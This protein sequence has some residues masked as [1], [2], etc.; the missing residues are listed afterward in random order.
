V[1]SWGATLVIKL[2]ERERERERESVSGWTLE[3]DL[4]R[5]Q[6]MHGRA[7]A[8]ALHMRQAV[9]GHSRHTPVSDASMAQLQVIT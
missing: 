9:A 6:A 4:P 5:V 3:A 1:G 7:K 8:A 2:R